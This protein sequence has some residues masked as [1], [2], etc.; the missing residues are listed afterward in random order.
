MSTTEDRSS[1]G[2]V[3]PADDR[4]LTEQEQALV[5]RLFSDPFVFPIQFKTW[6]ISYFESSDISL[7]IGAVSGLKNILGVAG[8]GGGILGVLPAGLIFEYGGATAPAGSLLC[9]GGSYLRTSYTRLFDAI[10]TRYGSIDVN[11]FNVPNY[12][13]KVGVGLDST[14][15]DF[16]TLGKTGGSKEVTLTVPQIPT[17]IHPAP[18]GAADYWGGDPSGGPGQIAGG[19]T[20]KVK[21]S[22]QTGGAGGGGAHS[23]MQ[24]FVVVNYIIVA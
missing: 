8:V 12:Q 16:D 7:P 4:P 1:E 9:D 21:N 19:T 11:H 13:K 14:D 2:R 22:V 23:N 17:H 5:R 6:L 10:G 18:P 3:G 15:V 24:P 20:Y